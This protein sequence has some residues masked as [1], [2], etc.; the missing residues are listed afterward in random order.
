[1]RGIYLNRIVVDSPNR[2]NLGAYLGDAPTPSPNTTAAT[3]MVAGVV[4]GGT[5]G[6]LLGAY[7][8]AKSGF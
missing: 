3:G 6:F 2:P 8:F 4:I 5:L 7:M 1:M